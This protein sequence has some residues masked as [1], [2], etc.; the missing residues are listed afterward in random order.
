MEISEKETTIEKE[1]KGKR[2]E[3]GDFPDGPLDKSLHFH[4]R[5]HGFDSWLGN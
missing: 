3:G 5:G 4:C 2:I 1:H